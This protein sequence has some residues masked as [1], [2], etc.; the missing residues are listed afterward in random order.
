MGPACAA[1]HPY[2]GCEGAAEVL[3][4][5]MALV[6]GLGAVTGCGCFMGPL[7]LASSQFLV[8]FC[9]GGRAVVV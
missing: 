9:G 4:Y 1:H 3:R 2:A 6:L 5:E 7:G 8:E